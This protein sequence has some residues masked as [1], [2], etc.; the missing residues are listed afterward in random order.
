MSSPCSLQR[1]L[2][3]RHYLHFAEGE[4][5]ALGGEPLVVL[6]SYGTAVKATRYSSCY[7]VDLEADCLQVCTV[8]RHLLSEPLL[9][10]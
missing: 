5:E 1:A 7:E 2:Q 3:R 10:S 4:M 9:A 8:V 6:A